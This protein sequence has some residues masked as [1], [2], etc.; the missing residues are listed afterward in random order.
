MR[1][2]SPVLLVSLLLACG[3]KNSGTDA[4]SSGDASTGGA[5]TSAASDSTA[6]TSTAAS[7]TTLPT[8][9]DTSTVTTA[10]TGASSGAGTTGEPAWCYGWE[11]A[12][13]APYL[14][15]HGR[16]EALLAN[17]G[18]IQLECGGQGSFM[19]GL[20][21]SFGGFTPP[22]DQISFDVVVDVA[23]HNT[24]PE[25]HFYSTTNSGYYVGCEPI[26]GGVLGVVPVIPPDNEDVLTLDGLPADFHVVLHTA[27]G[28]VVVDL[29]LT[30]AAKD[31]GSWAF[32]GQG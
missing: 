2:L 24:N 10:D 25:G 32:C 23:G 16:D 8:S 3:D 21:P 26:I 30:L 17:G 12:E 11:G 1:R 7:S 9:G 28:D 6:A 18:T 29:K 20:Y 22:G 4:S 14:E 31:D 27:N 15:L 13:G 5:S 19:F